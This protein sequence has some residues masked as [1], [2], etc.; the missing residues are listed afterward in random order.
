M[1]YIFNKWIFAERLKKAIAGNGY[2]KSNICNHVTRLGETKKNRKEHLK[3][4]RTTLN[5]LLSGKSVPSIEQLY[6]I[7]NF[8]HCSPEY[9]LG[10]DECTDRDTEYIH[11]ETGLSQ[12]AI[13]YFRNQSATSAWMIDY[14]ACNHPSILDKIFTQIGLCLSEHALFCL[15]EN[16]A[17]FTKRTDLYDSLFPDS[18]EILQHELNSCSSIVL[19]NDDIK[20]IKDSMDF[21][22]FGE[23]YYTNEYFNNTDYPEFDTTYSQITEA[24]SYAR[25]I[26]NEQE[27]KKKKTN[28]T[29]ST[30]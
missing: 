7:A 12:E 27:Q 2:K 18:D 13:K 28:K 20:D 25:D 17:L 30:R 16:K 19:I 1:E 4:E 3:M 29:I 24:C 6:D 8:L 22:D 26:L 23:G 5:S 10:I 14:L 9:L 11:K 15:A 21:L